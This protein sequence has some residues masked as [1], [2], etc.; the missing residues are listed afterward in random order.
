VIAGIGRLWADEVLWE[1]KIAPLRRAG[2]LDDDERAALR[3]AI[4]SR[5]DEAI[6]GYA[7]DLKLPLKDKMPVPERVHGRAGK[8]CPRCGS[9]ILAVHYESDEMAYCPTCQTG[10]KPY[11]DR[12]FSRLLKD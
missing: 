12:R 5:L 2:D 4:R 11:K 9:E 3:E 7:R 1:A 10:G 8:E 6:E